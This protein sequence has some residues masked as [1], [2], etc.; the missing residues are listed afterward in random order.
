MKFTQYVKTIIYVTAGILLLILHDAI[1]S[2]S[3][4]LLG[5]IVAG[6]VMLY[7]LDICFE[8]IKNKKFFGENALFFG[9]LV[10]FLIAASLFLVRSSIASVC[11]VWAV[12]GI[13]RES[14]EMSIALYDVIHR[15][16]GILSIIESIIIIGFSFTMIMRP[17]EEHASLHVYILGVE[18]ILEVTFPL[19]NLLYDLIVNKRAK[20]AT[21]E[22][23]NAPDGSAESEAAPVFDESDEALN[24]DIIAENVDSEDGEEAKT[25]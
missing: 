9:G 23:K 8:S 2:D 11:I 7:A 24:D 25:E 12:L 18:L 10:Q 4:N 5:I 16:P 15:K 19:I 14:K 22:E 21:S 20:K 1:M 3:K 17:S 6:S 13:L